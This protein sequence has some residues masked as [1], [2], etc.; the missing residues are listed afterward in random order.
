MKTNERRFKNFIIVSSSIQLFKLLI[1]VL[2]LFKFG[3]TPLL[4]FEKP[5]YILLYFLVT[6][7]PF[8]VLEIISFI[9]YKKR[10]SN[11]TEINKIFKKLLIIYLLLGYTIFSLTSMSQGNW[12]ISLEIHYSIFKYDSESTAIIF[13]NTIVLL[14]G[15][16]FDYPLLDC[17]LGIFLFIPYL[18]EKIVLKSNLKKPFVFYLFILPFVAYIFFFILIVHLSY[19]YSVIQFGWNSYFTYIAHVFKNLYSK[20]TFLVFHLALLIY[21]N[22]WLWQAIIVFVC[23]ILQYCIMKKNNIYQIN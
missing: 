21:P 5:L 9:L 14:Y 3:S 4:N 10:S 18:I 12:F 16:I 13:R 6:F 20:D 7:I 23:Y 15:Y 2:S 1:I 17:I 8:I 11:E 19:L 22:Y